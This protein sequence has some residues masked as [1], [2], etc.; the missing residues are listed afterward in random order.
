MKANKPTP[1]MTTTASLLVAVFKRLTIHIQDGDR[2]HGRE[3]ENH[4]EECRPRDCPNVNEARCFA[5][6]DRSRGEIFRPKNLLSKSLW[7]T[8]LQ[9]IGIHTLQSMQIAVTYISIEMR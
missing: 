2:L 3:K 4:T 1:E 7:V 6:I 9:I 8:T 5:E